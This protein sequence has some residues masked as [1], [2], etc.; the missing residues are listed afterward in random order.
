MVKTTAKKFKPTHKPRVPTNKYL[1]EGWRKLDLDL[2]DST[3]NIFKVP[4][5]QWKKR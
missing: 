5:K 3:E 2:K 1:E 4:A